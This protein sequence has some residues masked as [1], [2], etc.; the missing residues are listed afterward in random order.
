MGLDEAVYRK[1]ADELIRFAT[2]LVG[3]S[4]AEDLFVSAVLK[5]MSAPGWGEVTEPRA[6]LFRVVANEARML[7]RTDRRR[8]QREE[9]AVSSS[10]VAESTI[11]AEVRDALGRL[12]LLHRSVLFMAYWPEMTVAEIA[13]TL[14]ISSRSV[15]RALTQGR[16]L[17]EEALR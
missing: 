14:Q 11:S 3:P 16:R 2:T 10:S 1:Y 6:Y 12:S 4:L 5:A 7:W 9:R 15:E 17:L 13:A 8:R